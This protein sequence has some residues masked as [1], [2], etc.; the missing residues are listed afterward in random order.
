MIFQS[1]RGSGASYAQMQSD[2][3]LVLY[4]GSRNPKWS[5]GTAGNSKASLDMQVKTLV[6]ICFQ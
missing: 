3:N 5:S 2:G 4:D 6:F 1:N